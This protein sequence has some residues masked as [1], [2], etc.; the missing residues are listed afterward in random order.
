MNVELVVEERAWLDYLPDL[1]SIASI[2][3]SSA[4]TNSIQQVPGASMAL[5]ACDDARIAQLNAEFRDNQS[6]TNVLSWPAFDLAPTA[7][8]GVPSRPP[9]SAHDNVLHL[10]DVAIALQTCLH[11]SS[12]ADRPLKNHC[13]HLIL[14]GTLHLLGYDH[15]TEPDADVMEGIERK[16]LAGLGIPDPYA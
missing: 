2:A 13:L 12:T 5:L 6:P 9:V 3:A 1:Q 16:A 7:A 11:E 4:L 15:Q 10:G 14:H 8:G